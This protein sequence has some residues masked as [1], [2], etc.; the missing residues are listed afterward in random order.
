MIR[1]VVVEVERLVPHGKYRRVI[2]RRSK[3]MAHDEVGCQVGDRVRIVSTRPLSA[4]K[5]WRVLE[6]LQKTARTLG[7][8]ELELEN[9]LRRGEL[10][11]AEGA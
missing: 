10:T 7:K 6:V 11:G 8:P 2:R 5:R 3:F 1:S 4:R 9:A